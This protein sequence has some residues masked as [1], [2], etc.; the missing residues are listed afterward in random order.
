MHHLRP[1]R[2]AAAC[3]F[4]IVLLAVAAAAMQ[5]AVGAQTAKAT[6]APMFQVDPLWPKPLPNR[7][8]IGSTIGLAIDSRDHVWV[9]LRYPA[10]FPELRHHHRS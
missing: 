2:G 3:L 8:V 5:K 4:V 7:W 9:I 6:Q 1:H 10:D